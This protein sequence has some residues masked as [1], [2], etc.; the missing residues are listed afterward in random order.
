MGTMDFAPLSRSLIGF[1]KISKTLTL[2]SGWQL[3]AIQY[4]ED[5]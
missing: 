2:R 1:D 5:G 3:P 4:R